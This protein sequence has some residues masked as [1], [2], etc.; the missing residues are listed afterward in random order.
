MLS[1]SKAT[2]HA[3]SFP[4]LLF[5]FPLATFLLHDAVLDRKLM[6]TDCS[7]VY[8]ACVHVTND[9]PSAGRAN[10]R[11]G[12]LLH[13]PVLDGKPVPADVSM[14]DWPC[15]HVTGDLLLASRANVGIFF[16]QNLSV[17]DL[18]GMPAGP[19]M[20]Y[21]ARPYLAHH[22][23][24][25]IGTDVVATPSS[26]RC[27]WFRGQASLSTRVLSPLRRALRFVLRLGDICTSFCFSAFI[28]FLHFRFINVS[29]SSFF[30]HR[31]H[32]CGRPTLWLRYGNDGSTRLPANKQ[33]S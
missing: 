3:R 28:I 25:A 7:M 2:K 33:V 24:L 17:F 23:R 15:L 1:S 30:V 11:K 9:R 6:S 12:F 14:V 10:V 20:V 5:F 29:S 19:A 13:N 8:L 4:R 27:L 31:F 26:L 21:L 16:H 18:E 32:C 22:R